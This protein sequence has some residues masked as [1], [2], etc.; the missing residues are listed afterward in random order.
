M[1]VSL[2]C[3]SSAGQIQFLIPKQNGSCLSLPLV[4][5][6]TQKFEV[7]ATLEE[8]EAVPQNNT[9][10]FLLKVAP[11]KRVKILFV[12]G[13]P[14]YELGFIKRALKNDPNIQLTDRF[15]KG[16]TEGRP[17]Y[18]GTRAEASH[19]FQF[20]PDDKEMLFDF[21]AIILGN[22]DASQFTPAAAGEYS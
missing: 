6:V 17:T 20:Y 15:L 3:R 10:T 22:V 16:F 14:R 1:K 11:T 7:H 2:G 13:R 5:P 8:T 19:N 18:G 4:K 9:K 21:D 12:D